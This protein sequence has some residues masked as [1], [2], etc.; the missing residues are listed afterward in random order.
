MALWQ[1]GGSTVVFILP[2]IGDITL[3]Y[4]C[5]FVAPSTVAPEFSN[6]IVC[7]QLIAVYWIY[8]S[9]NFLNDIYVSRQSILPM[10]FLVAIIGR[11]IAVPVLLLH[12]GKDVQSTNFG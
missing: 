12:T 8:G 2:V 4:F 11:Y 1:P 10:G 9:V 7:F 5:H 6:V 3:T